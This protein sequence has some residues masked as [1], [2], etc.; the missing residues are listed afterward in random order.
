MVVCKTSS[1]NLKFNWN[2]CVPHTRARAKLNG[3]FRLSLSYLS[4]FRLSMPWR[5]LLL[6]YYGMLN[7]MGTA[8]VTYSNIHVIQSNSRNNSSDRLT[9]LQR[10]SGSVYVE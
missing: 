9:P 1:P 2:G 6:P 5:N 7:G 3:N 10:V 4:L 8:D